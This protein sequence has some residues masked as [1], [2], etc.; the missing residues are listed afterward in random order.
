MRHTFSLVLWILIALLFVQCAK[1]G[2]PT[3]GPEDETPPVLLR[4]VPELNATQFSEDRIRLYFVE[5][6]KLNKLKEQL[7][8]SPPLD[9][10][11]YIISPQSTAAKY[12]QIELLDSLRSNTTYNFNFGQSIVD[13]NEGNP[14]PYFRYVFSTGD[15]VDSLQV[16]GTIGNAFGREAKNFVSVMLYAVDST[17]TDSL[18]YNRPPDYLSNTLDSLAV[19]EIGNIRAGRYLLIAQKDIAN[20]YTFDQSAD[21]IAFANDFI[22]L[23]SDSLFHLDLFREQTDFS[24]GRSFQ[25][26]QNRIGL[27]YYGDPTGLEVVPLNLPDTVQTI[28]S[29]DKET[30]TLYVWY[31]KLKAD[32]LQFDIRYDTLKLQRTHQIRKAEVDSLTIS[33]SITGVL[34]LSDTLRMQTSTPIST[35]DKS[36][37]RLL[38]RDS[39]PVPFE[40]S[41]EDPHRILFDFDILPNDNYRLHVLPGAITDFFNSSNDTL[42]MQFRT[43]KPADYGSLYLQLVGVPSY[44]IIVQLTDENEN[45]VRSLPIAAPQRRVVFSNLQP[46]KYYVR[47]IVDEN[48]NGKWDSGRFLD[49]RNPEKIYHHKPLLDVR[50]NWELQEQFSVE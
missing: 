9:P 29:F 3:G 28:Q 5:Y 31:N 33:P 45:L 18:I 38:D 17:Y 27:G 2:N 26:G 44:P 50:A 46:K 43:Q 8:I 22:D 47:L 35:I 14:Y 1:R 25:A 23:P 10:A 40:V 11:A 48:N 39:I 36:Q 24:I 49:R 20:N 13:N 12:V 30:D 21:D 32:S 6:V 16:R 37:M 7:I 19:F 4:S 34:H 15:Y 41:V 42:Q